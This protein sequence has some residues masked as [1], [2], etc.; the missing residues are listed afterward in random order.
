M[1][2]NNQAKQWGLMLFLS[3]GLMAEQAN[4][5]SSHDWVTIKNSTIGLEASF[6]H[7]P[8]EMT[9]DLPFQNIPPKGRIHLYSV[10]IKTGLLV[11]ST[12]KSSEINSTWLKK[13]NLKEF[14]DQILVPHLFYNPQVFQNQQA[15][16]Y[17]TEQNKKNESQ[18]TFQIYYQDH[19][20]KKRIEGIALVKGDRLYTYF[21]LAS[22]K[23]FDQHLLKQ[24]VESVYFTQEA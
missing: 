18:G 16:T 6:P 23:G 22:D 15:L 12:L 20:E 3:G 21:Y 4:S 19:G 5:S 13:E 2:I 14:F 7:Q 10:P 9:F 11:L 8:I 1:N 17:K 24:F